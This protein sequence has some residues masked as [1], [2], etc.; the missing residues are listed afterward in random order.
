MPYYLSYATARLTM[1]K[2]NIVLGCGSAF[3]YRRKAQYYLVTAWHNLSGRRSDTLELLD[4]QNAAL[5][6]NLIADVGMQCRNADGSSSYFRVPAKFEFD[7]GTR[8]TYFVHKQRWPRVDVAIIPI[9]A[10]QE[11]QLECHLSD[12]SISE[13]SMPLSFSQPDG[14]QVSLLY[15]TDAETSAN[16][17]EDWEVVHTVGDDLFLLGYPMGITDHSLTPIWKRASI[18]TEP[19]ERWNGQE[20]I[21]VDAASRQGMSGC[22]AIYYS[23]NGVVP[24]Y[25]GSSLQISI[26][27]HILH[28]VYVG[29]LGSGHLE[30][31]LGIVWKKTVI[32]EIIDDGRPAI[33]SEQ[34]ECAV[35]DV[36]GAILNAWPE[37]VDPRL[38]ISREPPL[39]YFVHHL[40][41]ALDGRADPNFVAEKIR[42]I[43]ASKD[44]NSEQ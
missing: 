44:N 27:L 29:R 1:R 10:E 4:K 43:A 42:E 2:G 36:V 33:P 39:Y 30:A 21:L 14:S 25:P 20:Q 34:I 11:L 31:Q 40:M 5:P 12:G 15:L 7:D 9:E 6:D 13:Q 26:P 3:L 16:V 18:A 8:T 41:E 37:G 28:G 19:S 24:V 32:D 22:P 38:Y 17:T 35:N 23:K